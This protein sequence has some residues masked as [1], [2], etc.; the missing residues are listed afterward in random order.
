MVPAR[1]GS[2]ATHSREESLA[3]APPLML[4]AGDVYRF[5]GC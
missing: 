3:A 2:P 1:S 5:S 4:M